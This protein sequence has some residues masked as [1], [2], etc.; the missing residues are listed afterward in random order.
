MNQNPEQI[1]RDA[2]D[3]QLMAGGWVI[4]NKSGINIHAGPGVAV[5]EYV[6]AVGP[7]DYVLFVDAKPVGVIEAKREEEGARLSV[8]EGQAEGYAAAKLKY[9]DNGKLSFAYVSTGTVTML[10]DFRD[11]KPRAREVFSFHRPETMREWLKKPKSLRDSMFDMPELPV[12][13]LRDCQ[14]DA[15]RKLETS[16]RENKPRAL[17]QMA[18]GS[19]K[20]FTAITFVYRLL[21]YTN[22]RRV[23]FLVDTKNLG[24][25][26]EQEFMSYLPN[27][28]NRKFTE[29][30]GVHRLKS[31]YI[32]DDN[33]VYISTIQRLYA[34]LKGQDLPESEEETN[35]NELWQPKEVPQIEYSEKLP[36]EYFDFI[37]IDECHRS[38]YNLWMQVLD[39]FDAFQVGLTATPDKRTFAYFKQNIVSEYSHETAVADGVNV[40]YSVYLIDTKVSGHGGTLWKGEY[41]EHRE[42]LSRRKRLELQDEDEA[43]SAKQLDVD[44]V[45]PN[46][47]R[48]VVKTF[49]ERLPEMFPDRFDKEGAFEVPKTL[50]FAKTDSHADD[51]IQI[52]REEFAEENSFCKKI[53]Y[54]TE[55]DAKS[56]LA[57]FRNNYY[58]RI[59]VTVD[60]IATG[61]DVKPLECLLFMRDVKSRNY[62]EQMKG[63]GTRVI[64]F[65]DLKKVSPSARITKDHFVIVDAI[66]V[67]KS[68]KTDSR[69]LEK[70]P[71]VQLKD[72]LAAVAVGA[73]DEDLFTSLANRLT[74]LEK[75][76]TEKEQAKFTEK[77]GGVTIRDAVKSLLDAYNPD[78]LESL[79]DKAISE[80][81]LAPQREVE[82]RVQELETELRNKAAKVFTG[83]VNDYIENVRKAHDQKIDLLNP[84]ELLNAGWDKDNKG[85]AQKIIAD[86]T[87]WIGERKDKMTVLQ[88]FYSLPYR[89]R[90]LTFA[91]LKDL[92]EK[93]TSENQGLSPMTVWRAYEQLES[94]NGQPRNDQVALVSLIR[95]VAG[96]DSVLTP[97]DKTVDSNFKSWIFKKHAGAGK[98]FTEE[99]MEWLTMLKDHIATSVHV[100]IDDLDYVPFDAKGGR[101]RMW[102]LFGETMTTILFELNEALAA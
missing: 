31:R 98:K 57:Q 97:Y 16:F 28:D 27:D 61:T 48:M 99:Q 1:A 102:Q 22:A 73:R 56:V 36:P 2:I 29:L 77:T 49:K 82:K 4:Q 25:Q 24:E 47:I 100:D 83:E 51:I 58:P 96:I 54:K 53:T 5:R 12:S 37:V 15:I 45:N 20:T 42:R 76:I 43:Y 87:Q 81:P 26:A 18:T 63:R 10:T 89:R 68:L 40:G 90:E 66:G 23:L 70:K 69:P 32:P 94:V 38:I 21:K 19:G 55:E 101:G 92:V 3:R 86:F 17:I 74:R 46:Q 59:A 75:Q 44:I 71:G 41:I 84:D 35:P 7:A 67:T 88:I 64:N 79:R 65:D 60:M 80:L 6:T 14:I 93:M 72:L 78:T 13:G 8:H 95:H 50:V 52:I 34:V 11:P 62:F 91:M 85:K 30:Y 9:L 33:Q 39:Y